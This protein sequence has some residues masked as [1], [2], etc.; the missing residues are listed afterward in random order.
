LADYV[1]DEFE[2]GEEETVREMIQRAT[3]ALEVMILRGVKSAMNMYNRRNRPKP[4]EV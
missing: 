4:T 2:P 3:D 1:L